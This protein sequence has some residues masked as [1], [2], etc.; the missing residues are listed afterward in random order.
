MTEN[1]TS[2]SRRLWLAGL[3]LILALTTA[4]I[5]S[6]WM[7]VKPP[8]NKVVLISIDTLRAD[9]LGYMGYH[10]PTSPAID[11]L[12]AESIDFRNAFSQAP[13]TLPS[14][15]SIFT[16]V[17]PSVHRADPLTVTPLADGF[18]T[19]AEIFQQNGFRTA[20]FVEGGQLA[21]VWNADQGFEVYDVTEI[22]YGD[23][24]W[25]ADDVSGILAEAAAWIEEHRHES[26]FCFVH[27]YVVHAPYS[28]RP[29][30]DRM[31]DEGYEGPLPFHIEP[32][33]CEQL[34]ATPRRPD[35]PEVR[36]L[37]SLY[38]GEIR[39]MDDHLGAF[40]DKL[41][42]LGLKEETVVVFT[43]DHGEEF[44]VGLHGYNLYDEV[45]HVPLFIRVPGLAPQK[46][47][48]Q[49][50]LIDLAPTL[51]ALMNLDPGQAPFQGRNLFADGPEPPVD[52]P[53]PSEL[54]E[55]SIGHGAS[56]RM[57]GYKI[58][59]IRGLYFELFDLR[60]DPGEQVNLFGRD[61]EVD[62]MWKE[63]LREFVMANKRAA[64]QQAH[65]VELD[66]EVQR[67]LRALGYLR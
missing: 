52:L 42:D 20:A 24:Q 57:D 64:T 23:D 58:V 63:R 14:H 15:A 32:R 18:V 53:V 44:A 51:L 39:Y 38:D 6:F 13:S 47:D 1:S 56:L 60:N 33:V 3:V 41:R 27:S 35:E 62:Q 50:R 61:P 28:P 16:S 8:V 59:G 36:H 67:Q 10:R 11:Q 48:Q 49:V 29:P 45:L 5:L 46:V 26:F 12:A 21:A 4:I 37:V 30:Y 22:K 40:L 65:P 55:H 31:F 2:P 25:R 17:Y 7:R 34:S 9:H 19:L 54:L 43:S 66:A